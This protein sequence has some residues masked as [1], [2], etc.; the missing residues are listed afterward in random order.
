MGL[1]PATNSLGTLL[2]PEIRGMRDADL[3]K[4]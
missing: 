4:R 1:K 3:L 2:I